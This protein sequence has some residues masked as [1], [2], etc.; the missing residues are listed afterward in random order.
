MRALFTAPRNR[1]D[2]CPGVDAVLQ[3]LGDRFERVTL[4]ESN[5]TDCVSVIPDLELSPLGVLGFHRGLRLNVT[6]SPR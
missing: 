5:D 1:D 2:L 4:R 3:E 6:P